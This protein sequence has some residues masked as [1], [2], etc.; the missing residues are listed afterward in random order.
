MTK[1][2]AL[3]YVNVEVEADSEEEA[4]RLIDQ[5]GGEIKGKPEIA[6]FAKAEDAAW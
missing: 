5:P 3:L 2:R 4:K 6:Y 1:W